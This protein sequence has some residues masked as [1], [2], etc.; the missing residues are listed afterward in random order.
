M[1]DFD[2]I[3]GFEW[4]A[5]NGRKSEVKHGVTQ[6]EAEEVFF[7]NPLLISTDEKHSE[8]EGRFVALGKTNKARALTVI[9]T[10]RLD[11]TL[12]R[13]ISARDQHRK[14]RHLYEQANQ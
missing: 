4:D 2:L 7:N 6:A 9:F 3:V 11:K 14:E 10:L 1:I 8:N 5:G 12:I 13:V